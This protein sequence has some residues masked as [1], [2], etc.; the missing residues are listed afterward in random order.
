MIYFVCL[1]ENSQLLLH[2]IG[3]SSDGGAPP[4]EAAVNTR[5]WRRDV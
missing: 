5:M 1:V 3:L 4:V 2:R